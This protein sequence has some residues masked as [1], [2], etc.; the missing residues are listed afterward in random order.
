LQAI[1]KSQVKNGSFQQDHSFDLT[2]T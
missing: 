1:V 2:Q